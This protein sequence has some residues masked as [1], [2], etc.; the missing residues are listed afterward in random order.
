MNHTE[1]TCTFWKTLQSY[2][3][4]SFFSMVKQD[5]HQHR[6][7]PVE[8]DEL[9]DALLSIDNRR[10][11][12]NFLVDLCS[13]TELRT[14]SE[15]WRIARLLWQHVPYKCITA[16]MKTSSTTIARVSKSLYRRGSG[17]RV[18]L[19]AKASSNGGGRDGE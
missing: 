12:F 18:V 10:D 5:S 16:R 1:N 7:K 19:N 15:R 6:L 8:L 13:T 2:A 3:L 4:S 9:I 14:M 17:Y 11:G